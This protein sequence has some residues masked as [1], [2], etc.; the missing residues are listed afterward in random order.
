MLTKEF[1]VLA[2]EGLHAR[3]AS[4]LLKVIKKYHSAVTLIKGD[5]KA[6][7]H[8]ILGILSMQVSYNS[9][10]TIRVEG[11]DEADLMDSL[12]QFFEKDILA[13]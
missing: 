2:A 8:S 9:K 4:A 7:A 10:I 3:P 11:E 6:D 13:L 5:V 12:I 1:T